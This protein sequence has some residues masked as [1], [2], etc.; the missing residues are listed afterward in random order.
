MPVLIECPRIRTQ[1]IWILSGSFLLFR[2]KY[3]L[4][5][6]ELNWGEQS[7]ELMK[8]L[9]WFVDTETPGLRGNSEAP[10]GRKRKRPPWWLQL[11]RLLRRSPLCS[12]AEVRRRLKKK[13][14]KREE[15]AACLTSF[16]T[17]ST[18]TIFISHFELQVISDELP[19]WQNST[20]MIRRVLLISF[21]HGDPGAVL[22]S[23]KLVFFEL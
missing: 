22:G 15:P 10:H 7:F 23:N 13:I 12:K 9:L 3:V 1:A 21:S 19:R 8:S 16:A 2:I 18:W 6:A 20:W 17:K 4:P 11:Q 5:K 14:E